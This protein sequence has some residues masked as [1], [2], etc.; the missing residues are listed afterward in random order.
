MKSFGFLV[1]D[2]FHAVAF[3]ELSAVVAV[4][5]D[6]TEC[7]VVFGFIPVRRPV[8][9]GTGD[10]A[11]GFL[12]LAFRAAFLPVDI[13]NGLD[14]FELVAEFTLVAID[15]PLIVSNPCAAHRR[16][17]IMKST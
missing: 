7:G 13:G 17:L 3:C 8:E 11:L 10:V 6:L 15:Q 9:V 5:Y 16:S 12:R 14:D 4:S 1:P 2:L